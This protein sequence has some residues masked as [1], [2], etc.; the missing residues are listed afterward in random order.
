MNYFLL[1]VT[2]NLLFCPQKPVTG[3]SLYTFSKTVPSHSHC[4]ANVIRIKELLYSQVDQILSVTY[5]D[6]LKEQLDFFLLKYWTCKNFG[7]Y[8]KLFLF[9][10]K[11]FLW[12]V[13]ENMLFSIK[14]KH[15]ICSFTYWNNFHISNFFIV[16][17]FM[18][19][20]YYIMLLYC[21]LCHVH[22]V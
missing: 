3:Y 22:L 20:W 7:K 6:L 5:P 8:S 17:I 10:K 12:S 21:N 19:W 2:Q 18:M 13:F 1:L 14:R 11:I 4:F 16:I 15:R 9:F